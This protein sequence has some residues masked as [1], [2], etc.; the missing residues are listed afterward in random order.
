MDKHVAYSSLAILKKYDILL[1]K[2]LIILVCFGDCAP[3]YF[4]LNKE[5]ISTL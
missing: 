1:E 4:S 5:L 3:W 2:S